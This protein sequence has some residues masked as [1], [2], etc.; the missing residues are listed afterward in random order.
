MTRIAYLG[1]INMI[2]TFA[3]GNGAIVATGAGT[4]DLRVIHVGR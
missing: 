2:Y 1:G 4:G 3:A